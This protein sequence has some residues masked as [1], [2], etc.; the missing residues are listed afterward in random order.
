MERQSTRV[1]LSPYAFVLAGVM[2]AGLSPVLTKLLLLQNVAAEAIVAARYLLAVLLL[3]P[4]G[5][6]NQRRED[7]PPPDRR[8]W[9]TLV[10]VGVLGSGLG[11]LLFVHALDLSSAGV[12]NSISKTAP[13]FVAL[14][15]YFTL[16]ERV[17]HL[18]FLLVV[19][20]VSAVVLIGAG[21][22]TF[23]GE[24]VSTRL[25]GDALA[26]AA[27]MMRAGAE[28]LGK[29]A[30]RRF[31]P[32]TVALWR[33]GIGLAVTGVVAVAT[34]GWSSLGGLSPRGWL[35][36]LAL[37]WV[38]TSLSMVL[39]YRGLRDIPAHVAVSLKLLGA[40]VTVIVS[41]FVL[42]EAL[43]PYHMAGIGV[44]I[45]GAYLLVMRS[46]Q[47]PGDVA[48]VRRPGARLWAG[49][50]PRFIALVIALVVGSVTVVWYL[51]MRHSSQL[52]SQQVQLTIG[53]IGAILV[54]YGGLEERPSW[55][56]Y[57]QY[58]KRVIGHRV[59]GEMYSLEVVYAAAL[60]E[61]GNIGAFA[62][63]D[64]LKLVD[65]RGMTYAPGDRPA[66]QRFLAEMDAGEARRHGLM[67]AT[68][69]RMSGGRRVGTIKLGC[70]RQMQEG[71][72]GEIVG[73]SA[74]AALTVLLLAIAIAVVAGAGLVEPIE[75]LAA[76]MNRAQRPSETAA[77]PRYD[78]V[79]EIRYAVGR[80]VEQ[81]RGE[82]G[83]LAGLRRTL[84]SQVLAEAWRGEDAPGRRAALITD[85][86]EI[87]ASGGGAELE[88]IIEAVAHEV[89]AQGGSLRQASG[90]VLS[91]TWGDDG[92]ERDD[93]LRATLAGLAIRE[94]LRRAG[95]ES[96][97]LAVAAGQSA[98]EA[99][100]NARELAVADAAANEPELVASGE[101]LA[102]FEDHLRLQE[103]EG[104]A[105]IWR[106]LGL[107]NDDPA[108]DLASDPEEMT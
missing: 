56:S 2:L 107:A 64:R 49:I 20:M 66:Q 67:T 47:Q 99:V 77:A 28:I 78:E 39:Y 38:S 31:R 23:S 71:M 3:A 45:S 69:N 35:I 101:T 53:E 81:L 14:F 40:V 65:S 75:R 90:G 68:I 94:R 61:R 89:S 27:G 29:S 76:E 10:L 36:L 103:I 55:Q 108:R 9:V 58:L 22:L 26:L 93:L 21:E 24:L 59:S 34:G 43:T 50:R 83:A 62:I 8:A 84:A 19:V 60:D 63:S 37:G 5:L 57:Q 97:T 41:W 25:L 44:L 70:T 98:G 91:A 74:V 18:R 6:P 4:I 102:G 32:S 106:V 48:P 46:A 85:L 42:G 96:V 104:P 1:N 82:R 51:S 87:I 33:F 11:A 73:R 16:R 92:Y 54:D 15:A 13:I 12:V 7:A 95:V 80:V 30:L 86:R 88:L 100:A 52:L 72:V 17:T 79:G 105:D